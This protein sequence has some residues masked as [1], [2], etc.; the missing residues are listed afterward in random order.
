L[1]AE[2]ARA[3]EGA[4]AAAGGPPARQVIELRLYT[5]KSIEKRKAYE[6]FLA[7]TAIPALN[8]AGVGLVGAF[9]MLAA[10][11]KLKEDSPNLYVVLAHKS[12]ET[13]LA[14]PARLAADAEYQ[15]AGQAV[16]QAPKADPA[17]L[18]CE[19]TLMLA[20]EGHPQA[21]APTKAETRV[22]QLRIY[23]SHSEDRATKKIEMFNQGG[24][25]ALFRKTG[26]GIVFFGQSLAG[27][28]LPNLTYM[29]CFE[30]DKAREKAWA[31]FL[32]H[33]DW[34]KMKNDPIYKDT[35]SNITNLILRPIAGSQI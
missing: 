27:P 14:L 6:A 18:R 29:L 11:N 8:R 2:T 12:A 3:A 9:K 28:R 21:T 32:A 13:A 26:L 1:A 31:D 24:E 34:N 25:L 35:V 15:K 22:A 4:A 20:F 16:I 5:F 7:E 17:L 30:D 23:E 10:D 33:G 19:T